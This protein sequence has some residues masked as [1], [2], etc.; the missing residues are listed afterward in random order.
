[1]G[2]Q[3]RADAATFV[4]LVL[5]PHSVQVLGACFRYRFDR[6]ACIGSTN[7]GDSHER[8]SLKHERHF[9]HF[10]DGMFSDYCLNKRKASMSQL[11]Q[12]FTRLPI[13]APRP[14]SM[15]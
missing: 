10:P 8:L 12:E 2:V 13:V 15:R 4:A 1:M 9:T 6:L 5:L 3:T 14:R 11:L 7:V